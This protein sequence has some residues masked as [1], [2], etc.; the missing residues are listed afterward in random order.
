MHPQ[1]VLVDGSDTEEGYF[2]HAMRD[3][4]SEIPFNLIELPKNGLKQLSWIAKLDSSALSGGSLA[5]CKFIFGHH[6]ISI[7]LS[8]F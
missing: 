1:A 4:S 3:Q 2:L 5:T 8:H 6:S 7:C